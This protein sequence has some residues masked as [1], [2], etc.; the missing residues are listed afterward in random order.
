MKRKKHIHYQFKWFFWGCN[1]YIL[2]MRCPGRVE[3]ILLT[4]TMKMFLGKIKIAP[5]KPSEKIMYRILL[6]L[7]AHEH[8]KCNRNDEI[9]YWETLEWMR[10]RSQLTSQT[11]I[12]SRTQKLIEINFLR[13]VIEYV[14]GS[15]LGIVKFLWT[16]AIY[17]ICC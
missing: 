6:W 9:I 3:C 1:C 16:F 12:T 4:V 17:L 14:F 13:H 8:C 11:K 7:F 10:I 5:I 15:P 2:T